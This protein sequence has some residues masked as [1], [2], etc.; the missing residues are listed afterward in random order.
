[1]EITADVEMLIVVTTPIIVE[2]DYFSKE[3]VIGLLLLVLME[4]LFMQSDIIVMYLVI[5]LTTAPKY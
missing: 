5:S 1:M 3:S 4:P 2:W